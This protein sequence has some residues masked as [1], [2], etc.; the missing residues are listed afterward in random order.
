MDSPTLVKIQNS[1]RQTLKVLGNILGSTSDYVVYLYKPS[2]PCRIIGAQLNV[3]AASGGEL[4]PESDPEAYIYP[5][6]AISKAIVSDPQ[7]VKDSIVTGISITSAVSDSDIL[8]LD[9]GASD[10]THI[11]ANPGDD[12]QT[13]QNID[14]EAEEALFIKLEQ[15]TTT[16]LSGTLILEIQPL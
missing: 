6:L 11:P 3:I 10:N 12:Y 4:I 8:S 13:A 9:T 7:C 14:V 15:C 1:P 5:A 2:Y 16:A